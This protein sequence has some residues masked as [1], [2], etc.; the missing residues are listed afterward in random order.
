MDHRW[1]MLKPKSRVSSAAAGPVMVFCQVAV[2]HGGDPG[3]GH[4]IPPLQAGEGVPE[5]RP[6]LLQGVGPDAVLVPGGP[7]VIPGGNGGKAFPHRH[8][9]DAGGAEFYAE[10][11]FHLL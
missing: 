10:K 7:G 1:G 6:H 8:R 11:G 4:A 2:H 3:G 5:P 9:L